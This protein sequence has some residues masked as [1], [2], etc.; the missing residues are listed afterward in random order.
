MWK[1]IKG[2]QNILTITEKY[3]EKN[4]RMM[5]VLSQK[6]FASLHIYNYR[7]VTDFISPQICCAIRIWF[8]KTFLQ[9]WSLKKE[10]QGE[11]KKGKR[12]RKIQ[13]ENLGTFEF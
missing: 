11:K 13:L 5:E 8:L 12:K 7:S 6:P 3:G 9:I 2:I 4:R 1:E 10:K